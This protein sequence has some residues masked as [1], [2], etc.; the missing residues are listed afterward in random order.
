MCSEGLLSYWL[1]A[2][3]DYHGIRLWSSIGWSGVDL[4]F[5]LSGYLISGLLFSEYQHTGRIDV[6]RFWIRR[7]FKIYPG[8]YALVFAAFGA[9][10][11]ASGLHRFPWRA[12]LAEV[13]FV[14]DYFNNEIIEYGWSLGVEE[15]FYIFLPILL[16]GLL[17][18]G[19]RSWRI[20]PLISIVVAVT[21]LVWRVRTAGGDWPQTHLRIDGLF[22]GVALGYYKHF[23][24]ENFPTRSHFGFLLASVPC[25]LSIWLLPRA[26]GHT[27]GPSDL[28]YCFFGQCRGRRRIGGRQ[29]HLLG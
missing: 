14:R 21:C 3:F 5:V 12:V 10:L 16:V 4:L 29:D 19:K 28:L 22:C 23:D 7:G 13:F 27:F 24:P 17:R 18:L 9:L 2:H 26:L 6:V 25:L 11:L 1:A 8:F 15:H 20:L